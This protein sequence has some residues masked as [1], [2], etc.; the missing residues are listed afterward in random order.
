MERDIYRPVHPPVD[1]VDDAEHHDPA[2]RPGG[3]VLA[4]DRQYPKMESATIVMTTSLPGATQEVMQGFVTT[5]IA[6]AI[7]S[8]NGIE[9]LNSTSTLGHS[10]IKAKPVLNA[11]ADRS[12]TEV[13]AKVQQVKYRLP[14]APASSATASAAR[15][16]AGDLA[17]AGR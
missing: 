6:Q 9:Y 13:M 2:G 14:T 8:S 11:D 15:R 1:P 12:M 7:A 16:V 17:D 10:E 5:P 4:A 3:A